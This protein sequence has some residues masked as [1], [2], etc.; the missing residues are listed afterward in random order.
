MSNRCWSIDRVI[1]GAS[2]GN[3]ILK[4]VENV[5]VKPLLKNHMLKFGCRYIDDIKKDQMQH[6]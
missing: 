2:I 3:I 4:E 5:I 1:S 6:I